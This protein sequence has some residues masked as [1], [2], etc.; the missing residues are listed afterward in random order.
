[1][2]RLACYEMQTKGAI[3]LNESQENKASYP[4][5]SNSLIGVPVNG[6]NEFY[7]GYQIV[8]FAKQVK[9]KP[10]HHAIKVWES[11]VIGVFASQQGSGANSRQ[12]NIYAI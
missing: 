8:D 11:A 2:V 12:M 9:F 1:M 4:Q 7:D 10:R 5:N 3:S 6:N